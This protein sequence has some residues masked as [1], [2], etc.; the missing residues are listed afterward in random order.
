MSKWPK[1]M[2]HSKDMEGYARKKP[3]YLE[4]GEGPK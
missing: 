4:P 1:A 3:E 2:E